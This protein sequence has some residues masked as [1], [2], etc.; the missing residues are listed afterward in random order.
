[1]AARLAYASVRLLLFLEALL[2]AASFLLHATAIL[3]A[4]GP[5]AAYGVTLLAG[6]IVVGI[7]ATAFIKDGLRWKD[8]IKNCPAWMWKTALAL[9]AYALFLLCLQVIFPE[10]P[11]MSDQTLV[12]S[13]F[14]LGFD[15]IYFCVLYS[16]L[17][18][19]YLEKS[20]VIN[21]ARNSALGITLG[22]VVFLAYRAGY[23]HPPG[24]H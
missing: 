8:Q 11:S 18:T 17:K 7:P 20:E 10:G 6:T 15:G 13:G 24:R 3:G 1:M 16:V 9:G 5:C 21:R 12:V 2:L 19:S 23:L 4:K 14:P 22:I